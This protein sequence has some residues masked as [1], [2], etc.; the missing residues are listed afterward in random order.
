MK[1]SWVKGSEVLSNRASNIIR[2]Y[3]DHMRFVAFMTV[4]FITFFHILSLPFFYHCLYGCMFYMLLFNF[5]NFIFL[6]L[7][8]YILIYM[9]MYSYCYICSECSFSIFCSVYC[10]CVNVYFTTATGC[11]PNFS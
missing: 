4:L 6:L 10:F 1:Y 2:R 5:V 8:L 7:C 9:F 3:I 11:Q